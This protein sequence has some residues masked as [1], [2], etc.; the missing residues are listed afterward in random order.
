MAFSEGP[1]HGDHAGGK[2][3]QHPDLSLLHPPAS[4]QHFSLAEPNW[5]P[6]SK[7]AVDVIHE[8]RSPR[9]QSGAERA[10]SGSGGADGGNPAQE[11]P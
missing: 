7:G 2:G 11:L 10:E 8:G 6:E 3:D 9:G 5:K 4:F 1:Q